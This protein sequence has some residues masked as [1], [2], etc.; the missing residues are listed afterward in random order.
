MK[1]IAFILLSILALE[2]SAKVCQ[3]AIVD[4]TISAEE[5]TSYELKQ[6]KMLEQVL[7]RELKAKGFTITDAKN[8]DYVTYLPKIDCSEN[9]SHYECSF[10]QSELIIMNNKTQFYE[11]YFGYSRDKYGRWMKASKE[12][13][14]KNLFKNINECHNFKF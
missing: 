10:Y 9:F 5:K 6:E 3:I 7:T 1:K 2:V 4:N 11:V 8:A 12:L 14:I 13:A